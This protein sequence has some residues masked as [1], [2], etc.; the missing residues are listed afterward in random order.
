MS[1][2]T[3]LS[4]PAALHRRSFERALLEAIEPYR[5]G[6]SRFYRLVAG[7]RC[8]RALML[9][10]AQATYGSAQQFCVILSLLLDQA[11]DS[12]ARLALL[13][14]L[15]EEEGIEIRPGRGLV[16]RPARRHP[17]LALRFLRACGG[18]ADEGAA[19]PFGPAVELLRDGRWTEAVAFVLVGQE[20]KFADSS[21]K[22]FDLLR[23]F[24]LAEHDLAFFAVHG[25]ADLEHGRQAVGLVLDHARSRDEQDRCI[26]AA[27]AGARHWFELHGGRARD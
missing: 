10:Y 26:A 15:M 9:R 23:G 4:H 16:V 2:V 5:V 1:I 7:G 6:D 21:R 12:G 3:E 11:P 22:L 18:E 24:G 19:T 14:N 25:V 13:E 17:E 20:L 8:P 27:A